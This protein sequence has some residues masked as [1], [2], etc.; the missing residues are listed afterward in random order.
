MEIESNTKPS[1]GFETL[2]GLKTQ[3]LVS[4]D[5]L[6]GF[7][8]LM[9]CGADAFFRSLEGKTGLDWVDSVSLQ[10]EHPEWVG[11]AFYDFIFPLFL[12]ISGVSIPFSFSKKME[13][14]T[15]KKE[16]YR[17]A[18]VRMLILIDVSIHGFVLLDYRY[19][20]IPKVGFLLSSR[21]NEQFDDLHDL[22]ICQF[23]VFFQTF[24]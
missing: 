19:A 2:G 23:Q 12:F 22:P 5:A 3:R 8:M 10:F 16:I 17:K 18:F 1:K 4:I 20:E 6:R 13:S 7:D 21:R 11:F 24:V 9:I 14:Q 15:P